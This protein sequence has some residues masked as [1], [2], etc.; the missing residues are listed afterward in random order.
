MTD[1]IRP[2]TLRG[3]ELGTG[4]PKICVPLVASTVDDLRQTVAGLPEGAFDLVELRID[5]FVD[6]DDLDAVRIAIYAVREGVGENVPILFT[7]RSRPEGGSRDIE[8][9][10]Y[11]DLLASAVATG[12]VDA[13]DVEMFT[14][15]GM[16]EQIVNGAHEH[17]VSVVMSSHDFEKTPD[18]DQL[19]ARLALQQDLGADVLKLAVMPQSPADVLTLLTVTEEFVREQAH[20]PV[21]TMSMAALGVVTR[22]AGETFGSCLTFGSSGAASAPGQVEACELRGILDLVHGSL[23]DE[24]LGSGRGPADRRSPAAAAAEGEP[25]TGRDDIAARRDIAGRD[26]NDSFGRPAAAPAEG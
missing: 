5:H 23:D 18:H 11:R 8:P 22:L 6:V 10:H 24:G 14:E 15:L 26:R 4:R 2:V 3:L 25:G 21:I 12:Q 19:I 1:T 20:R 13:I 9:R 16:L 7:F 17:D